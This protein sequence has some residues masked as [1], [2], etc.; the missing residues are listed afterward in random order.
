MGLIQSN[1]AG[2][3]GGGGGG[4]LNI[5]GFAVDTRTQVASFS[6]GSLTIGLSQ[7]PI[8]EKAIVV[9][10]NGVRLIYNVGWSYSAG[11]ITILFGDAYV[12]DYESH[13]I[14]Q[15]TYPF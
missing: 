8:V 7:I 3:G 15:I 4:G 9:D 2:G 10:Y 5:T 14:F 1:R 11:I 13:P 6:A 12:E